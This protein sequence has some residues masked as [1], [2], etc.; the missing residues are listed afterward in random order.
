MAPPFSA[1]GAPVG[2]PTDLCH[3]GASMDLRELDSCG[4]GFVADARGRP[5]RAIVQTAL[6]GLACV[7]HRGALAADARTSDGSGLLVPIP[8]EIF[9]VDHGVAVLFVRGD[10]PRAAVE[11][12]A[13]A[14]VFT[15][16]DWR[17][18]PVD[19]DVLGDRARESKPEIL[20]AVLSGGHD[21]RFAELAAFRLRR[22]IAMSVG[23]TYVASC[24][25]RTV[26]YKGL[27]TADALSRYYLDLADERFAAPFAVFHQRFSTN[28]LP[29]WERA[30]PFRMLCHNGEVNTIQGNVNRMRAREGRLGKINLLEEELLRPV[31]DTG[32]S[33]SAMLDNVLELLTREGR[34]VRHAAAMLIP[35]AWETLT[36]IGDEVRDFYRY[37]SCL[38]E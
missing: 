7:K 4:I 37:H 2:P 22:R 20:Q 27:V 31:I 23:G 21:E 1:E 10:D 14:E 29:T 16:V 9:G 25:F 5:S 6:D 13:E 19:D 33:D 32:G 11:T 15:V 38:M 30:Q 18:P 24:S 35:A 36:D 17:R 26:L 3:S 28:T 8:P 12:A 34:D